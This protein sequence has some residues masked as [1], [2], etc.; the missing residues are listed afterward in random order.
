M[1]YKVRVESAARDDGRAIATALAELIEPA[2]QAVSEFA[3]DG[4]WH[5]E[6]Y[7]SQRP[8]PGQLSA[9]IAELL[10]ISPPTL[11]LEP[12][13]DRNWVA[14]SQTALPPVA[15]GRY[16]VHGSHDRTNVPRGPRSIEIDAGEAF[17]TAHHATTLSCLMTI[18]RLARAH[19]F[20]RVLDLGCGS[21]VLAIAAQRAWPKARVTA[22]DNDPIAVAVAAANC[23]QN[24]VLRIAVRLAGD[25]GP[26]LGPSRTYE[27]VLANILARP[28]IALAPAIAGAVA[29]G[30]M[31]V[32]SGIL[33]GEARE[34]RAAY[35]SRGFRLT[36]ESRMAGW[37]TLTLVRVPLRTKPRS[38]RRAGPWPAPRPDR[39]QAHAAVRR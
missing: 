20:R 39:S 1:L 6:A 32:I 38:A 7:Y 3:A 22:L 5:I 34:V 21:G 33:A 28:L 12:V 23:R 29:P 16:I 26:P 31:L 27:L 15:A 11:S 37:A 36:N 10:A 13:A 17:G 2:A 9:R 4:G 25:G 8:D 18:D 19:T 14:L 24:G 35:T 30:G